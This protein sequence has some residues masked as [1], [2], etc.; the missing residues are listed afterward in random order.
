MTAAERMRRMR[1]RRDPP[2]P[3]RADP[4][5]AVTE[6]LTARVA[7]LE[8]SLRARDA[9]VQEL[10]ASIRARDSGIAKPRAKPTPER[11]A[12]AGWEDDPRTKGLKTAI[13]NLKAE[14]AHVRKRQ[15]NEWVK[16]GGIPRATFN[17]VVRCLHSDNQPRT[18]KQR[19]EALGLFTQ[20]KQAERFRAD[21]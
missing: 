14:V 15:D 17:A 4:L 5:R 18:Q 10:A 7:E 9:H 21:A 12:A 16:A 6:S 2:K 20:W 19:D 3:P 13:K 1:L 11:P 8:A